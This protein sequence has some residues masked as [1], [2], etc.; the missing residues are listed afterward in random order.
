MVNR[1]F[2]V[3]LGLVVCTAGYAQEPELPLN[4]SGD[5]QCKV[6]NDGE[7][8]GYSFQAQI[9]I[10]T[11]G[12]VTGRM[13]ND[14]G[15]L[16]IKRLYYGEEWG[17]VRQVYLVLMDEDEYNPRLVLLAGKIHGLHFFYGE[18]FIKPYVK[19]GELEKLLY[20]DDKIATEIYETYK[21]EGLKKALKTFGSVGCFVIEG[22]P[23]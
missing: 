10:D 8:E 9:N 3:L 6:I 2:F 7:V 15:E 22:K 19:N 17:G 13:Y 12:W 1:V 20:L 14:E 21:P 5:G 18:I 11:D 23:E 16:K 4:W